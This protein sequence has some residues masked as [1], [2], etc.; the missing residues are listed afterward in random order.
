M[1]GLALVIDPLST[2]QEYAEA[3]RRG[4]VEPIAVLSGEPTELTRP[5]WHP[6]RFVRVHRLDTDFGGDVDRLAARLQEYEPVCLVPGS[7]PGVPLYDALEPLVLPGTGND[8]ALRAARCDKGAMGAAIAAAGLPHLRE[9]CSGD[10]DEIERWLTETDLLAEQVVVK[11]AN[12]YCTDNVHVV[13]PAADDW[14]SLVRSMVGIV[15]QLGR[16][17]DA[18]VVQEVARGVEYLV[19]TYSVGGRHGL[20]DVCRYGKY[21]RGDRIGIYDRVDFLPPHHPDVAVLEPYVLHVLDAVGVRNGCGHAE[22]MMTAQGPRL[23]EIGARPAGGGHQMISRL[24]TG[25]NHIDRTIAHRLAGEF[26][27]GYRLR[28]FVRGVFISAPREGVWRNAEVFDGV[29]D[30][31]TFHAK[32]FPHTTGD[33]VRATEDLGSFL[34]W[35]VLSGPDERAIDDDYRHLRE[36]ERCIVIE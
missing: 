27:A 5:S 1:T 33:H 8:P 6:E 25:D 14:K 23:I 19:D 36:R 7:E 13:T 18:V 28:Q 10:C 22:V 9:I 32:N 2:G 21:G 3:F 15:N 26:R 31:P 12:S 20:V 11:P 16:L 30:L 24:A 4:G 29:D 34:A 35:V 17:T